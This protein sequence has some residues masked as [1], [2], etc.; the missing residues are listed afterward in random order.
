MRRY[1]L[2]R[3]LLMIPVILGVI[4]LVFTLMYLAP[5]DAVS[6]ILG[7]GY[8][9]EAAASLREEL[10]LNDPYLVQLG[11][12]LLQLVHLDFGDSW[13][14]GVPVAQELLG[15]A[16]RTLLLGSASIVVTA[17]CGISLGIVAAIHQNKW[18]DTVS[19][20]LALLGTSLPN[21]FFAL[22]L[23]LVFAYYLNWLPAYGLGGIEHYILPIIANSVGGIAMLTRQTRSS[24]LEVIRSDYITMAKS[25]GL[26]NRQIIFQHMLPNA[27]IPVLTTIGMQ[28][29]GVIGG[30]IIIETVF[31]IPGVGYYLVTGCNNRDYTVVMGCTI[32]I[33]VTFSLIM[34]PV[35]LLMAAIDPRIKAQFAE[36]GARKRRRGNA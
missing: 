32:V 14:S 13:V 1:I 22:L 4:I 20:V 3:L 24:M 2:K 21:F 10:G 18:P 34:L 25:K 26:S 28:F 7:S 9:E 35:D 11:R 8:T 31:S 30:G 17:V 6:V 36:S 29:A 16:P 23:V 15:R 27:M 5:G 19:T 33:S 12:Y